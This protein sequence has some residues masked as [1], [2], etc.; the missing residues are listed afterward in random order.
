MAPPTTAVLSTSQPPPFPFLPRTDASS[1]AYQQDVSFPSQHFSQPMPYDD[2][3]I[4]YSSTS[5]YPSQQDDRKQ[6]DHPEDDRE[7]GQV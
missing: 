3:S 1:V 6:D 2:S 5:S 4:K 7:M